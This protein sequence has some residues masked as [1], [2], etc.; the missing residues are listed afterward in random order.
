[1]IKQWRGKQSAPPF[2]GSSCCEALTADLRRLQHHEAL[3]SRSESPGDDSERV[4]QKS[5]GKSF[6]KYGKHDPYYGVMFYYGVASLFWA[7]ELT[8]AARYY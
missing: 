8:R 2:C 6:S 1:M 4:E 3:Q 7:Q 5:K